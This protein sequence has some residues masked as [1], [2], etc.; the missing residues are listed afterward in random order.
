MNGSLD[1]T[2]ACVYGNFMAR[3]K[4][5]HALPTTAQNSQTDEE[6]A[7]TGTGHYL[8][9]AMVCV[10]AALTVVAVVAYLFPPKDVPPDLPQHVQTPPPPEAT[11]TLPAAAIEISNE[12]LQT[13]AVT[14]AEA[15]R[16][17]FPKDPGGLHVSAMLYAGLQQTEKAEPLWRECIAL[18]PRHVGPRVGLA[19]VLTERGQDEAAIETLNAALADGCSSPEA[20]HLL[21]TVLTKLGRLN[22]ADDALRKGI[23]V[24]PSVAELWFL[25]GQTQNQL[26]QFAEAETSL[27]K[28]VGLGHESAAAYFAL[29]NACM[30]QGKAEEAAVYRKRF[31]EMKA[32]HSQASEDL[33]FYKSYGGALRPIV[34]STFSGAAAVYSKQSDPSQAE[35]LFLRA[36]ALIPENPQVLGELSALYLQLGRVADAKVVNERLVTLEPN[37]VIYHINLASVSAQLGDYQRAEEALQR[38]I[39]LKPDF[40]LPYLS[41]AQLYL[42]TGQ[43]EKARSFA[44]QG[45]RLAPTPGAYEIL[46]AVCQRLG[47]TEAAGAAHQMAQK[48]AAGDSQTQPAAP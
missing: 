30:R 20:Y 41:R 24:Y 32:Q 10:G 34:A 6:R 48:L 40:A 46:A 47:D 7:A 11:I 38:A 26:Q 44:E 4:K 5:K 9:L 12:Q 14:E 8:R 37:Q 23:A 25:L 18:E 35:R 16:S 39:E 22:D 2:V 36:L 3:K 19:S 42:Q 17:R 45:I 15:L 43:F 27:Q 13:E 1:V 29:A 28:A 21:A 31:S 33:P